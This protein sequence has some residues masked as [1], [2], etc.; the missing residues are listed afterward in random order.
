MTVDSTLRRLIRQHIL[1]TPQL[2]TAEIAVSVTDGIVRLRGRVENSE[3]E[4]M[5]I[6][7]AQHVHGVRDV[8]SE[9]HFAAA[10]P[11]YLT[12]LTIEKGLRDALE[13]PDG[14]VSVVVRNGTVALKGIVRWNYQKEAALQVGRSTGL[15]LEDGIEVNPGSTDGTD[16][17]SVSDALRRD[18]H[19]SCAD[20]D[21]VVSGQTV[22]L[23]GSVP[24]EEEKEN[25][26]EI[27]RTIRG[28]KDVKNALYVR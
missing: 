17:D 26:E 3:L 21:V 28:V 20:I 24:S 10:D 19:I 7:L 8:Q 11:D 25:A 22:M 9:L 2:D 4:R 1:C 27:V 14:R 23:V 12:R 13:V 18:G 6:E 15:Q 16:K 5:V